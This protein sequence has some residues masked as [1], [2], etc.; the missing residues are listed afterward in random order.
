MLES[1]PPLRVLVDRSIPETQVRPIDVRVCYASDRSWTSIYRSWPPGSTGACRL[2]S[3]CY[4]YGDACLMMVPG[5]VPRHLAESYSPD[6]SG[7]GL[8]PVRPRVD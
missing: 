7:V 8:V 3:R 2:C 1:R 5:T 6:R 4:A